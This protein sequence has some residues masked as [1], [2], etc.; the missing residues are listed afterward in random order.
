MYVIK[1]RKTQ[2]NR[3]RKIHMFIRIQNAVYCVSAIVKLE[4]CSLDSKVLWVYMSHGECG[5][6][7]YRSAAEAAE[8]F[9]EI[10]AQLLKY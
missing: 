3:E 4:T 7:R 5:T 6:H 1:G 9:E 8:A 10:S 2:T